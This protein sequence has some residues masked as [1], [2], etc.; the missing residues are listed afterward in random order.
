MTDAAQPTP[1][2]FRATLGLFATGVAVVSAR[3]GDLAH[4]MTANAI[5]SVSLD[6][7]LVLVCVERDAI[8]RKVIDEVGGFSLSVL[9]TDQEHLSRWF[10]DPIRPNGTAQFDGIAHRPAPVTGAPLLDGAL[11][12][13]DCTLDASHQAGDHF[14]FIGRV[15]WLGRSGG[16]DPLIYFG[17]RYR[18]LA[19]RAT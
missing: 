4:G 18:E 3:A 6:P 19:D 9:A 2:E 5:A 13:V 11:A 14:I 17:S 12:W 15:R 1:D 10:A 16:R 7:L 8:M